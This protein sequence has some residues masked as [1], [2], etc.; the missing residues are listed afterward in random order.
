MD[1]GDSVLMAAIG[2][3]IRAIC[4]I[5]NARGPLH[6]RQVSDQ[7]TGVECTNVHK[8][9]QRAARMGIVT[10][11]G[12]VYRLSTDWETIID[13]SGKPKPKPE[14]EHH[15]VKPIVNSVWSLANV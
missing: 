4:A 9:L 7:L 8:C 3:Q 10:R 12:T 14:P 11:Q 5:L 6:Y 1:L 15:I 13:A 2:N